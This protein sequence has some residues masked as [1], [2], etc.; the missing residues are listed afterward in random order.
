MATSRHFAVINRTNK[1]AE[2]RRERTPFCNMTACVD[3]MADLICINSVLPRWRRI[4]ILQVIYRV[5][6]NFFCL[7]F[8]I[9]LM[10]RWR[11][12]AILK[13]YEANMNDT[14]F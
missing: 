10:S 8:M 12:E 2:M 4:A 14:L 11:L 7:A 13:F 6:L 3:K 9:V 1:M 5:D